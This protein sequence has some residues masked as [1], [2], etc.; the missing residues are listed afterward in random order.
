MYRSLW[1]RWDAQIHTPGT[2][3]DQQYIGEAA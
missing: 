2:A 1:Q 3:P